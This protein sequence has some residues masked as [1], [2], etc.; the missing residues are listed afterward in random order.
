MRTY[1]EHDQKNCWHPSDQ[2]NKHIVDPF[3]VRVVL[4]HEHDDNV[5]EDTHNSRADTQVAYAGK[6]L[7]FSIWKFS[8]LISFEKKSIFQ[9]LFINFK[10]V[11]GF[12]ICSWQTEKVETIHFKV[13]SNLF[14]IAKKK[15]K[16]WWRADEKTKIA[17]C[18]VFQSNIHSM[19]VFV[20]R[21]V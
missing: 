1:C 19:F 20:A 3:P 7:K 5:N 8:R 13:T 9:R 21:S 6:N 16:K 17:Y 2:N 15:L 10:N 12:K 11:H 18:F 14:R 4:D